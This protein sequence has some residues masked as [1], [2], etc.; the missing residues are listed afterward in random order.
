MS[1][2]AVAAARA[3]RAGLVPLVGQQRDLVGD[4]EEQ[5]VAVVR[6][7]SA[8]ERSGTGVTRSSWER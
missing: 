6:Q 8:P 1:E 5:P 7:V 2:L 3:P 4:L